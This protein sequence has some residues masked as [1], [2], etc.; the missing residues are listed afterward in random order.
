MDICVFIT[1]T[2]LIPLLGLYTLCWK[3]KLEDAKGVIRSRKLKKDR[4]HK[5]QKKKDKRTN[6]QIITQTE[7]RLTRTPIKT[8]MTSGAPEE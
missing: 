8:G 5:S 4:Q 6:L 1:I 3:E 2:G 7:D